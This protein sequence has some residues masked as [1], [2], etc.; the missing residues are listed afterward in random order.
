MIIVLWFIVVVICGQNASEPPPSTKVNSSA[1]Q[2]WGKGSD[3]EDTVK[4]QSST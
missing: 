3:S 4:V 1:V 2:G